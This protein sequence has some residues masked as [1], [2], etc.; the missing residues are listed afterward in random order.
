MKEVVKIDY[1]A[2]N[3]QSVRFAFERLGVKALLTK[4]HR[5]I[6]NAEKVI[7]PG[8]GEAGSAMAEIKKHGLEKTI[9]ELKQPVLGICLG[10][11]LMCNYSEESNTSCLDIF[12]LKVKKFNNKLKI[13]Q[14]GWNEL[15]NLQTR[16]FN[17]VDEKSYVYFAN[18]YYVETSEYTIAE[19]DYGG[20]FSAALNKDNF[21]TCQFH[22]E[23]SSD[24]GV[25]ILKN[26]L[27]L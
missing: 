18:S 8:V 11:Q 21:Y 1:G 15:K 7:F 19:T 23:K 10:M 26:F 9:P 13:P 25:R 14:M 4:N 3:V 22:P 2:G 6:E 17:N 20:K 24:V 12:P 16:L 27:E 5:I